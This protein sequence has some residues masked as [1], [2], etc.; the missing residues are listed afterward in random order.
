MD[1]ITIR[2][3]AKLSG[4]SVSTV[5]RAINN[6]PDINEK[7]RAKVMNTIK[8]YHYVP[9]NSA[10]NLKR[11]ETNTIAVLIKGISNTLFTDMIEVLER[12]IS[13]KKYS[14]ILQHVEEFEDEAEV[15][16]QLEKEKRLKGI[17]F[18][19]GVIDRQDERLR[20]LSVPFV[21][22]TVEPVDEENEY[23]SVSVDDVKESRR[24]VDYLC[25]CGHTRIALLAAG[26]KDVS[27]GMRRQK[28]Y[29]ESLENHGIPCDDSLIFWTREGLPTFSMESGYQLTKELLESG[30]D[31]TCIYAISDNIA[32]GA[33]K[34]LFDAGKRIPEDYSVAGFDGLPLSTYYE[35]S[36]TTVRQP[37]QEMAKATVDL[38]F[39]LMKEKTVEKKQIF[40]AELVIGKSTRT[41]L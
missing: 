8:E 25:D 12:E 6:H 11:S 36:I 33:C 10:R 27:V 24:M 18:L 5:S 40:E 38:L 30:R 32:I 37:C 15:A 35:P 29:M 9:N 31:F 28:G 4:L 19:G 16:L 34:A 26:Q 22:S 1:Q 17:I 23:A 2:D 13:Q 21:F 7:T 3:I 41:L 39:D 14:F 20:R